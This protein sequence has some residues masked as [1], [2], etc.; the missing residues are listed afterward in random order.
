MIEPGEPTFRVERDEV[1]ATFFDAA[2]ENRLL[3]RKCVVCGRLY[4]PYQLRCVDGDE[5]TWQPAAGRAVLRSWAVDHGRPLTPELAP[6][7]GGP[8]LVGMVE[9]DEGP[10]MSVALV[11]TPPG[12]LHEGLEMTVEFVALGGGEPVPVFA[13][14][15]AVE[16]ELR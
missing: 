14:A 16:G 5:F 8:A 11:G 2:R 4:P 13:P 15:G 10:W 1:S 9:L 3:L 12:A 7:D 6:P